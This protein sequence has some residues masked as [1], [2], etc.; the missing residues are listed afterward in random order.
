MAI[1]R[2]YK[3][4]R[5]P[6]QVDLEPAFPDDKHFD[7]EGLSGRGRWSYVFK[8][9]FPT[10]KYEGRRAL[11]FVKEELEVRQIRIMSSPR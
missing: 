6:L 1:R 2:Q 11:K 9:N 8:V 3:R 4:A 7:I 5:K 10:G